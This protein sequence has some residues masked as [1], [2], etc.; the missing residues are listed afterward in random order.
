VAKNTAADE[1]RPL[2]DGEVK[3]ACQQTCPAQAI[4]FGDLMD[5]DSAI[6]QRLHS[7]RGYHALG[8]LNTYSSIT[9][10]KKVLRTSPVV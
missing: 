2:K 10:L 9:Y 1:A 4:V 7:D 8:D 6:N 5:P 3:T